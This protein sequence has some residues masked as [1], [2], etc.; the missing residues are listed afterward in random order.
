MNPRRDA[1]SAKA[2]GDG[3]AD[4]A[5]D[6]REQ[7]L[8]GAIRELIKARES[9]DE[10]D[11]QAWL[12][13]YPEF[14]QELTAY[15]ETDDQLHW[16]VHTAVPAEPASGIRFGPYRIVRV[17][18]KGGMG[19]VYEVEEAG[20]HRP[21]ALKVLPT[22]GLPDP[23]SRARFRREAEALTQL[24][25]PNIVPIL[26]FLEIG[27]IPAIV[28]P[29]IEGV[30]LRVIRR[31]LD[32]ARKGDSSSGRETGSDGPA[33]HVV[34][35]PDEPEEQAQFDG[36]SPPWRAIGLIGLQAARA[37]AHAH[38]RGILHRDV[39]PSNLVL[40]SR[41]TV[42]LTDFGLADPTG[43]GQAEITAT[44]EVVGTLR[45][46]APERL[47]GWRDPR[48]D[49]YSLGLT[50][51]ELLVTR[52]AFALVDRSRLLRAIE[53]ESPPRPRKSR[54]DIPRDLE[55]I[56]LKA[57]Q[58]E[59]RDRYHSA[60]ALADD[61][62]RFLE[63]KPIAARLPGAGDRL[64]RWAGRNVRAVAATAVVL[65][66]VIVSL[67]LSLASVAKARKQA[68]A[69]AE[70]ATQ[71]KQKAL[72]A[73][74]DSQYESLAQ[75]FLR[76]LWS[77][78]GCGWTDEARE[79]IAAMGDIRKDDRL[80]SLG[81]ATRRGLDAH[82]TDSLSPGGQDVLFD[83]EGRRLL[84]SGVSASG[85]RGVNRGTTVWD[86]VAGTSRESNIKSHGP[87][88][89]RRDGTP[90]QLTLNPDH[91]G[92]LQLWD[93]AG[94]RVVAE[95]TIHSAQG[96]A[97]GEQRS[98]A[99]VIHDLAMSR[100]GALIAAA[101][102]DQDDKPF[103]QIWDGATGSRLLRISA[104]ARGAVFAPDGSLLAG[105]DD[106]EKIHVWSIPDGA[107]VFSPP[108][109]RL[110]VNSLAFGRNPQPGSAS[111]IVVDR[112]SGKRGWWL[113]VGDDGGNLTLWEVETGVLHAR[114]RGHGPAVGALAFSPDGTLLAVGG[115]NLATLWDVATG[116]KLLDLQNL[117]YC[118]GMSFSP[119][120]K[121]LAAGWALPVSSD[122]ADDQSRVETWKIEDG[123]GIQRLRGLSNPFPAV[124]FSPDSRYV[125]AL[126]SDWRV[127]IWDRPAG[128]LLHVLTP[129]ESVLAD[130]AGLAFSRDGRRFAFAAG[131]DATLWDLGS[132]RLIDHWTLPRGISDRLRF[133]PS[134]ELVLVRVETTSLERAPTR[135]AD[136]RQY[137]RVVRVR[138]L[139]SS[140]QMR[141]MLEVT[142]FNRHVF[143]HDITRDLRYIVLDGM[144]ID[145]EGHHHSI[146]A[147]EAVTG[148]PMWTIPR[149]TEPDGGEVQFDESGHHLLVQIDAEG[150]SRLLAM[151]GGTPVEEM[152][153]PVALGPDAREMVAQLPASWTGG[154]V[155]CLIR[156][157]EGHPLLT[158]GEDFM[159]YRADRFV[160]SADGRFLAWG[161]S[162]GTIDVA[163][164]DV[165]RPGGET[166]RPER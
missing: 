50:L 26:A 113:A 116:T 57:I 46:V 38:E 143:G 147:F 16:L 164:L 151:P 146:I 13:R 58:K 162:D 148:K 53:Q 4:D 71:E 69:A 22:C 134:G 25:H 47:H 52:P 154:G 31:Q 118:L 98:V 88:A 159:P 82:I 44:G 129:P 119:D 108:Q 11:R 8:N 27:G 2:N 158:F 51:Y 133:V 61:L 43:P 140:G 103:L 77:N 87:L 105:T 14:Q 40:D 23:D 142:H 35:N 36:T 130:H 73:A 19:V 102:K 155:Y 29:L 123:R 101:V 48:S 54:R 112:G 3:R 67:S 70:Q 65:S 64:A 126:S 18:G 86:T 149:G 166:S 63:G 106:A 30:D 94:E 160:F 66:M 131:T 153:R 42:L 128:A 21:L 78:H 125:A 124:E 68:L 132:G 139:L 156:R 96:P 97:A 92:S 41:G 138:T 152:K 163:D 7:Q 6:E 5:T 32:R 9:G 91:P 85:F 137:P 165:I 60:S 104:H 34:A 28:M 93:V 39:K 84:I 79:I 107:E 145:V 24:D 89:F 115:N 15:L 45:Y 114:L 110:S 17:I 59:P 76:L 1:L 75:R 117:H 33:P 100:D 10:P 72:A 120:G 135:D 49:I 157:G 95:F 150:Q 109:S 20:A 80:Q 83:S 122:A 62:Q 55:T 121:R 12:A 141:T 161:N 136:Y 56:V 74:R 111:G 90:L 127:A 144:R 81:D 37:L 99:V